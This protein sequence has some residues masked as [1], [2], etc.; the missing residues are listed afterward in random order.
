MT[1]TCGESFADVR[2]GVGE[3]E[4]VAL[5][6]DPGPDSPDDWV[7]AAETMRIFRSVKMSPDAAVTILTRAHAGMIRTRA[8]LMII[9]GR[10]E[11]DFELPKVFWWAKGHA[12]I[13]QNWEV[14][15]FSTRATPQND[16]WVQ[17]FGVRFHRAGLEEML[18]GAFAIEPSR[19]AEAAPKESGGRPLSALWPEWVA[20]LVAEI[21]DKGFPAGL[22]TKGAE[23][24]INRV[25]DGLA[26]R[27]L[28]G[29]SRSTVQ[30]TINAVLRR[31]RSAGNPD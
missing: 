12:A 17:A 30:E 22:G 20:E 11:T 28:D 18:P 31:H 21:N 10:S 1:L 24:L 3:D 2:W 19:I 29:P 27:G 6:D 16:Q 8:N 25:A 15:D 7:S 23:E 5:T 4:P 13:K 26:A 9:G 14:G